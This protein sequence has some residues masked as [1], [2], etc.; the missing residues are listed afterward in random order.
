MSTTNHSHIDATLRLLVA[1]RRH[2]V[3]NAVVALTDQIEWIVTMT[4]TTSGSML[5]V[6]SAIEGS[7]DSIFVFV[8]HLLIGLDPFHRTDAMEDVPVLSVGVATALLSVQEVIPLCRHHFTLHTLQV[9]TKFSLLLYFFS[10]LLVHAV[11]SRRIWRR[12]TQNFVS[13]H[14]KETS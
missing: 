12:A 13:T 5:Q 7:I 6:S 10:L 3:R 11:E 4:T 2:S 1:T 14:T 8:V 9:L